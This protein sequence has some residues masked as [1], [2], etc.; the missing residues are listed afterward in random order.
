MNSDGTRPE[1]YDLANDPKETKNL[2]AS[3]RQRALRM[4]AALMAWRKALP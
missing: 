4:Q 2:V 3:Q 1:L